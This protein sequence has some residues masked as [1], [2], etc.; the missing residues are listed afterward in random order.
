MLSESSGSARK[1]CLA[2]GI[3]RKFPR[4]TAGLRTSV[5]TTGAPGA[6]VVRLHPH[7]RNFHMPRAQAKKKKR[8]GNN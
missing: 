8:N 1:P 2:L 3:M 5:V 6:V 7:P 4:G